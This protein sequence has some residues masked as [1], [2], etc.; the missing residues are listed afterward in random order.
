MKNLLHSDHPFRIFAISGLLTIAGILGVALGSGL[1]AAMIVI[2]LIIVELA[3]SFDNAIINA[4]TLAKL[5]PL[6]QKLFLTIGIFIAVIGMRVIF[7]IMIVAISAGLGWGTVI[8][9][10]LNHPKEYA[11]KLEAAYPAISAFGGGFLMMLALEFFID[12][13]RKVLWFRFLEKPLQRLSHLWAPGLLSAA[14]VIAIAAVP[15]NHHPK[16]TLVAGFLGI[17]THTAIELLTNFFGSH[18]KTGN[19]KLPL[20]GMAAF[21]TFLYLEVL[22][23]SFSFDGVIGAF[24]I[25]S[26]IVL[27]AIGLGIGAVWVRSMTVFMVKKRTLGNYIYLEHGAHYTVLIL[28]FVLLLS[29]FL[30]IP[31]V[32][33][34]VVGI[35]FIISSVIASRQALQARNTAA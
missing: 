16:T 34:G 5:S 32:V 35:G 12:R 22:D 30:H 2:V 8:D 9:L 20:T 6:W 24:A 18:Q 19:S 29:A 25:T 1:S 26:D 17:L 7:P 13:N 28:A 3:F 21:S 15:A 31:E 11:E 10:A 33:T 14:A 27:I 4:K 23:A